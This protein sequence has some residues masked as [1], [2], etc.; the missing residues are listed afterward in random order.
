MASGR[1]QSYGPSCTFWTTS[2]G[3][4]TRIV[5]MPAWP[6]LSISPVPTIARVGETPKN[7]FGTDADADVVAGPK[8]TAPSTM[9]DAAAARQPGGLRLARLLPARGAG[10]Q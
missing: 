6:M 2:Q 8:V 3:R 5:P 7:L 4:G 10:L 9:I 1:D